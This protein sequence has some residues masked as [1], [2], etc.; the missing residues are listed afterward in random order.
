[1]KIIVTGGGSG[2]HITPTLA[3]VHEL[4]RLRPDAQITY[5]GQT[6]DPLLDV[7]Q[8]D[9]NVSAVLSIRAG[10]FRRYHGAGWRQLFDVETLYKNLRDVVL[11]LVGIGQSYKLLGK[12]RPDI[13]FIKG[14]FVGVPVGLAAAMRGIPFVTH[15]SDALP[16]LANRVIA[17]WA[18]VHAVALPKEVYA[19]YYPAGKTVTVG[20]PV[21][22]NFHRVSASEDKD[23]R[24]E[25]GLPTSGKVSGCCAKR[26][27]TSFLHAAVL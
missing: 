15:D 11:V 19:H 12:L 2:G 17:R 6:G 13:I 25:V 1:M 9:K 7:P 8:Q 23:W 20:V 21:S 27:R 24:A 14:G 26:S 16:G 10:K 4:K 3:V 5:I 18:K 22:H